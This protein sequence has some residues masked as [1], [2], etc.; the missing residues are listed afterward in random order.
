MI[1]LPNFSYDCPK[2][3]SLLQ[4]G[5]TK[6]VFQCESKL[7]QSWLKKIAPANIWEL[8]AVI[9]LV[10]PGPLKSGFADDYVAYKK[11]LKEFE[12]FGH[13]IIDEV[14]STTEHVLLYQESLMALGSKLAFQHL[15]EIKRAIKVDNL[16]KGV[17]KKDQAKL[18]AIGKEFTAGCLQN[19]VTEEVANKLFEV[20]KNCGRYLFNLSHSVVYAH[21]AYDTAWLKANY[22]L[23]FTSVYLTY[24]QFKQGQRK[25]NE[26]LAGKFKEIQE[27]I[28][29]SPSLGIEIL[30][31]NFNERNENFKIIDDKI[32]YGLSHIKSFGHSTFDKIKDY[33]IIDNWHKFFIMA[34]TDVYGSK[35]NV[36]S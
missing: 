17:G 25:H 35:I 3:W 10:R 8:S 11:G 28:I 14:F 23:E 7:V 2:T 20:I 18:I 16:R 15:D 24:A 32:I 1:D 30:P 6:G 4:S 29:E 36:R 34:S 27:F 31:P 5:L 21:L 33:P 19:G 13:P 26:E 22:P 12:S 9:A